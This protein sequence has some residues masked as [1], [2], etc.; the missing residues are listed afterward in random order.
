MEREKTTEARLTTKNFSG[1]QKS[2]TDAQGI[3]LI[4][5]LAFIPF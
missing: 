4:K 2:L 5:S 1:F 3:C